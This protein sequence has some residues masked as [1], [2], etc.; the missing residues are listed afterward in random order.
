MA[1]HLFAERFQ[2][3][4]H[5]RLKLSRG[6][7]SV[8]LVGV[9]FYAFFGWLDLWPRAFL[10][11]HGKD[12]M[13]YS[14]IWVFIS[15]FIA[16]FI[17]LAWGYWKEN[18]APR[19]D[20]VLHHVLGLLAAG[21]TLYYEAGYAIV[22]ISL[23]TEMMPVTTGLGAWAELREDA[24]LERLAK[25]LRLAVL[26]LWR[27]PLWLFELVVIVWNLTSQELGDLRIV[28]YF[29]LAMAVS[30][31]VLDSWWISRCWPSAKE[32]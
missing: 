17:W 20:L 3:P 23:T 21:L 22:M 14:L 1:L 6:L 5:L 4:F 19:Q 10:A 15:H 11:A 9:G 12:S 25:R 2:A 24:E 7:A 28:F 16:D 32:K 13:L 30:F 8:A 31:V 29:G 27:M 18:S 26:L